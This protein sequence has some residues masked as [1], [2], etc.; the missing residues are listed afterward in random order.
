MKCELC[1]KALRVFGRLCQDCI[2]MGR[3]ILDAL[4][5]TKQADVL[6]KFAKQMEQ[7]QKPSDA[8]SMGIG[9]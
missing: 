9:L 4:R 8:V 6:K 5:N 3:R 1:Q 7:Q 2:D